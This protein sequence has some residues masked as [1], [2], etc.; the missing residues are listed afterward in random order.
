MGFLSEIVTETQATVAKGSYLANLRPA[1]PLPG[2]RRMT[3]AIQHAGPAGAVIVE[4]K[5]VSPGS[6]SPRLPVVSPEEFVRR[7]EPGGVA[8]YSCLATVPRFEGSPAEVMRLVGA[9]ERP[10]LFKDFVIDPVQLDAAVCAG[11]SAVLL[12]ARLQTEGHLSVPLA[13]LSQQARARGL[14]VLLEYHAR[15]ELN[16]TSNVEADMYGVNVRDLDTLRMEPEVAAAT[17]RAARDR[18]PLIGLSGVGSPEDARRFWD[19]GVDGI[20]VGSAVARSTDP[21]AFVRSLHRSRGRRT[22]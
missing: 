17:L 22:P 8:A 12:I 14:E 7:A 11:A 9:T 19:A 4:F 18:R 20:L 21:A 2:S 5:R 16:A 15:S 3:V 10:V 1:Q 6:T 13:E